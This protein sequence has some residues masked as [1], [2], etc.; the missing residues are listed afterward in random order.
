MP[1]AGPDAM[2]LRDLVA[3]EAMRRVFADANRVQKYLDF[4]AALARVEAG[5]GIIPQQAAD[6]IARHCRVEAFDL[7]RLAAD[8]AAVGAP[9]QPVLDQ[10]ARLCRD[11]LGAWRHYGATTQDVMDTATI[12]QIRE[13][14]ALIEADL[15]AIMDG[16]AAL[17]RA[18]RDAPM[19]G[20]SYLQH[21]VPTT[22]GFKVSCVLDAFLRHRARLTELKPR[23][24]VGEFG[25]AVGTLAAL[26]GRGL[27]VQAAL[28]AELGLAAPAIAWHS[29]RD[30]IAEIGAFLSLVT[31]TCAKFARDIA[32]LAQTEVAEA[33]EPAA[34]GRGSSSAMPQKRN[35]VSCALIGMA[36]PL[37][38]VQASALMEA[39]VGEHERA[40]G[41]WQIEW[42]A[43]P[44]IFCLASGVLTQTRLLATGLE[45][46]AARMRANL[47]AASGLA[48][49]EAV[50][51]GLAPHLGLP[52]AQRFVSA[53][54]GEAVA[55]GRPLADLVAEKAPALAAERPAIAG[56]FDCAA[57]AP[58]CDPASYLGAAGAM[59]DRVLAAWE[60]ERGSAR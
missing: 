2:S 49:A 58:L 11:G 34:P 15:T 19:A 33:A 17:A 1:T 13:A 8:A 18:H 50:A 60:A 24:L 52:P 46:D 26:G 41:P 5:L 21:A 4:E 44:E 16:L 30:R 35:P 37:V 43:V 28:M 27:E 55:S 12:L 36:A 9:V 47:D 31:G 25:G 20:R 38:R 54:C 51:M 53:L 7:A 39:M 57:I 14:L 40:A 45:V 56:R 10:L 42:I 22:F 59:I 3:T 23:L 32:M 48:M 6:E 29:A